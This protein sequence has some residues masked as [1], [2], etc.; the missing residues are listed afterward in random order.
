M[1]TKM[2]AGAAMVAALGSAPALADPAPTDP[3]VVNALHF[4]QLEFG[5]PAN[6][7]TASQAQ[8]GIVETTPKVDLASAEDTL[9]RAVAGAPAA[10]AEAMLSQAGARC[11]P[12]A[13][14]EG[15]TCRYFAVETRDEYVDSVMLKRD[16]AL[17]NGRV[18]NASL[19]RTWLRH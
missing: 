2:F 13:G 14:G 11:R 8:T 6:P 5:M 10:D 16:L 3:I 1:L 7:L 17:S 18:Q 12:T 19:R 15:A 9:N 4:S